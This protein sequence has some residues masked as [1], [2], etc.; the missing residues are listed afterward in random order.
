MSDENEKDEEAFFSD[1]FSVLFNPHQFVLDFKQSVPQVE[2]SGEKSEQKTVTWHRPIMV[3]P[4]LAKKLS[5]VL[6]KNVEKFEEKFGEI[7]I[8][9][10]EEEEKERKGDSKEPSYIG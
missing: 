1:S 8:G 5:K 10:E 4:I 2:A 9:K 7:K 6:G 3:N